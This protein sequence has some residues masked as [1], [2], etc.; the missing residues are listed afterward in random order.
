MPRLIETETRTGTL[1]AAVNHL[2]AEGG[3]R[4]VSLRAVASV[5]RVSGS[6]IIHHLGSMEHLLRVSAHRTGQARRDRLRQRWP[7]EGLAAYLP[8]VPDDVV[9][10]RTWLAWCELWRS[11]EGLELTV[12]QALE[13]ERA[14]LAGQLDYALGRDDLDLLVALI[15]G[16][17]VATCRPVDPMPTTRAITLLL[18]A[19]PRSAQPLA[20]AAASRSAVTIAS[21]SS[22]E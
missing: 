15:E 7:D 12:R 11:E 4:A 8:S 19:V 14:L 5:S 1:V 17:T 13:E 6:S 3:P 10:A 2:L 22:A 16:L 21:G 18:G 9:D 20:A